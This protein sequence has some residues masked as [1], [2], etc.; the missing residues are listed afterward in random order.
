[1]KIKEGDKIVIR[2]KRDDIP[3][4]SIEDAL[5]CAKMM[6]MSAKYGKVLSIWNDTIGACVACVVDDAD[7]VKVLERAPS[8]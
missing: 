8:K 2:G 4:T 5:S 3:S 1:M 7:G 6:I